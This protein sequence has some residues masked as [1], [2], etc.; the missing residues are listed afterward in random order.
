MKHEVCF[1]STLQLIVIILYK[2][3]KDYDQDK[4][5]IIYIIAPRRYKREAIEKARLL[6]KRY[7]NTEIRILYEGK[8]KDRIDKIIDVCLEAS[9]V[10]SP[11]VW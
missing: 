3:E 8:D 4:P 5:H 9:K 11:S 2:H 7:P 10:L 6:E 1:M